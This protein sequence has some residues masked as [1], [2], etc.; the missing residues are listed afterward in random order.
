MDFLEANGVTVL[1]WPALSP[2]LN[3]IENMWGLLVQAV[4]KDVK[5]FLTIEDL[6]CAIKRYWDS[7]P[8]DVIMSLCNSFY[9]RILEVH[10]CK[11]SF[12]S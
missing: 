12:L 8:T 6:R 7:I 1:T 4:Y 11:G 9:E 3:I 5:A 2:D 10:R